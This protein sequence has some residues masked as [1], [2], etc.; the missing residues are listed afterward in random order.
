[1]IPA[2]AVIGSIGHDDPAAP[3]LLALVLILTAANLAGD[4]AVRLGQPA[5]LGELVA[6]VVLGNLDL[7]GIGRFQV[8]ESNATVETLARLGV[9]VLLFEVGLESTVRDMLKVGFRIR[10]SGHVTPSRVRIS[11]EMA[12]MLRSRDHNCCMKAS[13]GSSS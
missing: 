5:V 3:V 1:M 13:A 7:M 9:I 6:G 2:P 8:L 10:R 11:F 4:L 12:R